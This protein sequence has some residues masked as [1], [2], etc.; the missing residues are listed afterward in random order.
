MNNKYQSN[1]EA[2]KSLKRYFITMLCC[3]PLL[4]MVGIFLENKVNKAVRIT[5]FVLIMLVVFVIVEFIYAK[6]RVRN[7]N[8]P[9]I[10]HEDV[11]K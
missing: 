3:I 5:I 1:L 7:E 9:K 8:K 6:L 4:I 10:K 11:F 2:K